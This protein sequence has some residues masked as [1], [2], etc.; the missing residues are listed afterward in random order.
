M[1][2][3]LS[4]LAEQSGSLTTIENSGKRQDCSDGQAQ[5]TAPTE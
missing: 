3:F 2:L 4:F 1:Q 5:G